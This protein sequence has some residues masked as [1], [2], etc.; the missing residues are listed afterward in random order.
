MEQPSLTVS[1]TLFRDGPYIS[2]LSS[3]CSVLAWYLIA[4]SRLRLAAR[5]P[6]K[7]SRR[8]LKRLLRSVRWYR[9]KA[10][11]YEVF[12]A[13]RLSAGPDSLGR[14]SR[15]CLVLSWRSPCGPKGIE[16][17]SRKRRRLAQNRNRSNTGRRHTQS[18]ASQRLFAARLPQAQW[19]DCESL[20]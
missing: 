13:F 4:L 10:Q 17:L 18:T 7:R 20:R 2:W 15:Q 6:L 14:R 8:N 11:S 1:S 19:T 9:P 12:I 3:C 16:R 5:N